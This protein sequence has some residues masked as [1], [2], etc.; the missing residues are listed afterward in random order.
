MEENN[1]HIDTSCLS[2]YNPFGDM[3]R[4]L[5]KRK[6]LTQKQ[7]SNIVLC[8]THI[9]SN[10][11]RGKFPSRPTGISIPVLKP[12]LKQKLCDTLCDCDTHVNLFHE[13]YSL[14]FLIGHPP[15]GD[16][17]FFNEVL[18]LLPFLKDWQLTLT[19]EMCKFHKKF[20][21]EKSELDLFD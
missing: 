2:S 19:T 1:Y 12:E 17:R 8:P 11:E 3:V 7:L 4:R 13:A 5:R 9:I 20:I 21:D 14:S 18:T 6:E 16:S 15:N 10:I